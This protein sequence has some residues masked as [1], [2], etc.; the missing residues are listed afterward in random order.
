MPFHHATFDN[1]LELV[2]ELNPAAQSAA[3]GF[4]VKTGSRD[5]SP[6]EH[7]VSHF[8]EHMVFKGN[9][10]FSADDVNRAFDE[11]GADYN[12]ATGEETTLYYAAVLPEYLPRALDIFA[13]ILRPALRDDDFETE[14]Q[15]ILEEIG[16]YD[17]QPSAVAY[18]HA[19]QLHFGDHPLGRTILGTTES[20]S[21]LTADQMRSYHGEHYRAGNIVL[22]VAGRA[23]WPDVLA[24][25]KRHCGGWPEGQ[26]HR[27][28][29]APRYSGQELLVTREAL[30][31]QLVVQLAAAPDVHDP[32]RYAAGLL[33]LI[34]G[35]AQNS[36]LFWEIVDPGHAET[37]ELSYT[38]Y[39]DAGTYLFFLGGDPEETDA[40]LERGARVFDA[41][42][43]DG[44]GDEELRT[45][46]TKLA[47]RIVLRGERP[48]GRLSS[49]GGNWVARREYRTIADDL[50]T[51][52][53]ITQDDIR[54]VL[55]RF[56]LMPRT[57]VGVGPKGSLSWSGSS[58]GPRPRSGVIPGG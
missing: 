31:Q 50:A 46:K 15:V 14:K 22:A 37:A 24:L 33:A 28:L 27:T 18:D 12:A 21:R 32:L 56:P 11:I 51:V 30:Q 49:L 20:I 40:N 4:F 7:G 44:V 38:D 9:E 52:E 35:D 47:S 3:F 5:E 36:R 48:M 57:T 17:D 25:A 41:V 2:A 43:R 26:S 1:G 23:E 55:K 58:S 8:L 16:M 54:E 10:R 53:S 29:V 13:S 19:M 34:V 42:N 39:D 45:A 6:E